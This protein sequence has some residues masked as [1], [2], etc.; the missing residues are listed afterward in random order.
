[1]RLLMGLVLCV[2]MNQSFATETA[3][4]LNEKSLNTIFKKIHDKTEGKLNF[5]LSNIK[6]SD[7]DRAEI[8]ADIKLNGK[9]ACRDIFADKEAFKHTPKIV[10]ELYQSRGDRSIPV[11]QGNTLREVEWIFQVFGINADINHWRASWNA[12]VEEVA[13][14]TCYL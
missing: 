5:E 6:Q 1:M 10:V 14:P 11:R 9:D 12:Y 2:L 7:D 4:I 3:F 13:I 8:I